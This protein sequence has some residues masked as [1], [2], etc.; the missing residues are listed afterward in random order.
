MLLSNSL[1]K[2]GANNVEE[3]RSHHK[4]FLGKGEM[5][6]RKGV[7]IKRRG[8]KITRREF[9]G[10]SAAAAA[11]FTI[12]SGCSMGRLIRP[13]PSNKINVAFI[14]TGG[15]GCGNIK[16]ILRHQDVQVIAVC[17]VNEESDYTRFYYDDPTA[18][19]KPALK[20]V[21]AYY[22]EGT[23]SGTYKGCTG[24][25]DFREM[26][27]KEK[28][29]DA[30]VVSTPDHV[31]AVA[32]MAAIKK[33]KHVFCEK[34]LTHSVYETRMVTEAARKA[35]V[36]TQMGNHGNSEEGIRLTVEWIRDGAIGPVREVHAWTS[37][38]GAEWTDL[39]DRP[40][41][42]P[43]VPETLDWDRWL[44]PALY[45][46]YHPAY[47]PYNWRGWWDFGT[48][49]IG[50][51]ACHNIDPA[52]WALNLSSPTSVEASCSRLNDETVPTAALYHYEFPARGDMPPLFLKW[53]DGGLQPARPKEL[54]EGRRM[55]EDGIDFVGEDGVIICGGWSGSPR[56][57]PESKMK[58]YKRPPETIPRTKG[59]KRSWIDACKGGDAGSANFDYSGPLTE[60]V[61][62]GNV[63]LRTGK[64][65]YWDGANMKATNAPEADKFIKPV[66]REGWSL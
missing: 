13:T 57:I 39:S 8:R 17:D 14:G 33:G 52:F 29:I 47:A 20:I 56:I 24:Y 54:E 62:L 63:A 15:Q 44:G 5:M 18:G 31:H 40:R 26:L 43:P 22:A 55:G 45:R 48:G 65:I 23:K 61:L 53:Y 6:K 42:T 19:L 2:I 21:E 10:S 60:L 64:K 27:E 50:D 34:P 25:V 4:A 1:R 37:S 51:M 41:E 3:M 38:G 12:G 32:C 16:D 28:G 59:H 49:A 35:G 30:V 46:P 66:F 11:V 58:A 7:N 9:I 36:A